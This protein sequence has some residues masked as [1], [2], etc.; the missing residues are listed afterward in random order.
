M[1]RTA[2]IIGLGLIGGS[3]AL[4]IRREH[5]V[6]IRGFD[7]SQEQLKMAQSLKIVDE[8]AASIEEGVKG[9]DLIILATPVA[10]TEELLME[11]THYD[12]KKR[13]D[14]NRCR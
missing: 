7:I 14:T 8:N 3:I 9:A 11:L 5:D 10:K 6:H 2:F 13:S 1:K 4:A 12:L